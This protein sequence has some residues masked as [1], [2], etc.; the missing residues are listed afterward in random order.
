M[1]WGKTFTNHVSGQENSFPK[2]I[3]N[4][5]NARKQT[6]QKYGKDMNTYFTKEDIHMVKMHMK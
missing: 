3:K 6:N 5:Q 1:D 2:Y 4:F